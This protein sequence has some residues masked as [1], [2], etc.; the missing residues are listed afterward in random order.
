LQPG[1]DCGARAEREVREELGIEERSLFPSMTALGEPP[2]KGHKER[3]LRSP[4]AGSLPSEQV[5][6]YLC[7]H[8]AFLTLTFGR[9]GSI[10]SG[11]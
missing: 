7:Q 2:L 6:T 1:E 9:S 5:R 10:V 8:N 3:N 4:A 11:H